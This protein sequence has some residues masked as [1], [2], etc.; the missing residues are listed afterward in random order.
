MTNI[1]SQSYHD[2]ITQLFDDYFNIA[3]RRINDVVNE[4]QATK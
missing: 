2:I 1:S 3:K 4:G